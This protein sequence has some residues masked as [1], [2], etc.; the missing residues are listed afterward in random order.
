MSNS[1]GFGGTNGALLFRRW[2]QWISARVLSRQ[3]LFYPTNHN[4][5]PAESS[6]GL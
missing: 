2:A 4:P 5:C 1:F 3:V 6:Q